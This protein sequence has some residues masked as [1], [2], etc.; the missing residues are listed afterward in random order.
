MCG[1][2]DIDCIVVA[3]EE[4]IV[5]DFTFISLWSDDMK[6]L[7]VENEVITGRAYALVCYLHPSWNT[8]WGVIFSELVNVET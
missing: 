2:M 3:V 4:S 5:K 1:L 6:N 8:D 7:Y